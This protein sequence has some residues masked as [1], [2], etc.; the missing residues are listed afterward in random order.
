MCLC[1]AIAY[2]P[3]SENFWQLGDFGF[4]PR[5]LLGNPM[6]IHSSLLPSFYM[7]TYILS[8]E[9]W[10]Q[11]SVLYKASCLISCHS[12]GGIDHTVA[13]SAMIISLL[14][15]LPSVL[16][17]NAAPQISAAATDLTSQL[18][19]T[20]T[21]PVF[22]FYLQNNSTSQATSSHL[23]RTLTKDDIDFASIN[24]R[25]NSRSRSRSY[26]PQFNISSTVS[27]S[28]T[29]TP[30]F[31]LGITRPI[32]HNTRVSSSP[33]S[34]YSHNG[35]WRGTRDHRSSK[36]VRKTAEFRRV[37]GNRRFLELVSTN[38][39]RDTFWDMC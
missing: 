13:R 6:I 12:V 14:A 30:S 20:V 11:N 7:L 34:L 22:H 36:H 1:S 39:Q 28:G 2:L 9:N 35:R 24:T 15:L 33:I 3:S 25:R 17:V 31:T 37:S 4:Y 8:E 29:V 5:S 27:T 21:S 18:L 16:L 19:R 26:R 10:R 23:F 32:Q 38:G